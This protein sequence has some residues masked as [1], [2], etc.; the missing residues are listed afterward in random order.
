MGVS[1]VVRCE[2]II[3]LIRTR[4]AHGHY[5]DSPGHFELVSS[6]EEPHASQY[7]DDNAVFSLAMIVKK[8]N[9]HE[10]VGAERTWQT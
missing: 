7:S 5:L 9:N 1:Q 2:V 10:N 8:L 6:H 3:K 4:Y